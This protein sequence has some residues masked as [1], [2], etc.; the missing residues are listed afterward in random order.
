MKLVF[1]TRMNLLKLSRSA[2]V[3]AAV[4]AAR[5]ARVVRVMPELM[6]SSGDVRRLRIPAEAGYGGSQFE[7][8][9]K[10]AMP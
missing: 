5:E 1:A 6:S 3:A 10:P 4:A 9:D 7:V 8:S 2:T